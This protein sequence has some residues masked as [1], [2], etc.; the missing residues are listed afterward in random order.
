MK[1]RTNAKEDSRADDDS[2]ILE[3]TPEMALPDQS[4]AKIVELTN[5][6]NSPHASPSES[7]MVD[8]TGSSEP[9]DQAPV[10]PAQPSQVEQQAD[11]VFEAAQIEQDERIK[12]QARKDQLLDQLSDLTDRVDKAAARASDPD[13]ETTD[14][15]PPHDNTAADTELPGREQPQAVDEPQFDEDQLAQDSALIDTALASDAEDDDI[16]ELTEIVDSHELD[17]EIGLMPVTLETD[18]EDE[19]LLELADIIDPRRRQ[20]AKPAAPED[21]EAIDELDDL[22]QLTE[23]VDTTEVQQEIEPGPELAAP[24]L[25][26]FQ[27]DDEGIIELTDI[28]DDSAEPE[29]RD[30]AGS[31]ST[32]AV[33]VDDDIIELTQVID[34][35]LPEEKTRDGLPSEQAD[36]ADDDIIDLV[37]IV[38]DRAESE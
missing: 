21:S 13:H 7:L 5:A 24:Q 9:V 38:D 30:Q 32:E 12:A 15:A 1:E 29:V 22:I 19:E 18:Q 26:A 6:H 20:S 36:P 8:T 16:I 28:V 34:P 23:V 27:E 31:S 11:V 17:P 4:K 33:S 37:N 35:D 10:S 3:L 25:D 2:G 14:Q